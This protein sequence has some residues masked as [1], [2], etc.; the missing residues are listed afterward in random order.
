MVDPGSAWQNTA[1]S[2]AVGS[3]PWCTRCIQAR[4]LRTFRAAIAKLPYLAE[5]RRY[6]Y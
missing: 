5:S 1:E 6:R 4:S 3:R 2:A